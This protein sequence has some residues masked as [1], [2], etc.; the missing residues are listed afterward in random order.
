[1]LF[2]KQLNHPKRLKT[3][4]K[5]F[6]IIYV[7]FKELKNLNSPNVA[8]GTKY[9]IMPELFGANILKQN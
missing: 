2:L 8:L 7:T 5:L 4:L 6:F 3:P 1:M 9:H